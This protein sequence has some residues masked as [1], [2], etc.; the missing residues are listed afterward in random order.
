MIKVNIITLIMIN[1]YNPL[2]QFEIRDYIVIDAPILGYLHLSLTNIGLYLFI[3]FAIIV[4]ILGN[5]N[6]LPKIIFRSWVLFK[7]TIYDT[8]CNVVINQINKNKGQIYF[9]LIFTL[10]IFILMN[11]LIGLIPYSFSATSHFL[12]AFSWSFTIVIGTLFLGLSIHKLEFFALFV[13]Q[14][15]PLVLLPFLIL[16][17]TISFIS[18]NISLGL[19]LAANM[20]AGHMLLVILSGLT[21]NIFKS[22]LIG[23]LGVL[24]L[25]FI[26]AFSFLEFGIAFIQAQVFVILTAGY[27]KDS[28]ELH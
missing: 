10:F 23:I 9:P 14:G 2:D 16:I 25:L 11:N 12:L 13:P 17:E 1:F 22:G 5:I 24:P 19:R 15:C 28:I 21:L 20:L 26:I 6:K 18:R 8:L 7:E 4:I 3:A 27:I